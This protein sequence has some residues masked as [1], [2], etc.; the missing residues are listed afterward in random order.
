M[1]MPNP[2]QFDEPSQA[3]S[4][5]LNLLVSYAGWRKQSWADQL[6]HLLEPMGVNLYRAGSG[7]EATD[8][9]QQ[10]PVHMAVV[11]LRLPL[12]AAA[13]PSAPAA[14]AATNSRTP[15]TETGGMRLIQILRR[16]ESP[17]PT[18][19]V[20][21]PADPALANQRTLNEALRA[22]VFAVMDA[23]VA[24]E[25]LLEIMR[26][27]LRRYYANTWPGGRE[28]GSTNRNS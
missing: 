3:Q 20:R 13:G 19:V 18:V 14:G 4:P 22:G 17:P 7:R 25:Q 16:L 21:H 24:L 6:P 15:A 8:L 2:S 5:R 26:R 27:I 28:P 10:Y 23:P 11:D 12:D 9:I 1:V